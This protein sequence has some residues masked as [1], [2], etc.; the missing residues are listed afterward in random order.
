MFL[1]YNHGTEL[2]CI[3]GQ[4]RLNTIKEYI[5]QDSESDPW[6]W[7][8][9]DDERTEYIYY[10]N[11]DTEA[12]IITFCKQ[13]NSKKR[14]NKFHRLMTPV[15][16]KR[17]REY[18]CMITEI[19][20]PLT[21]EERQDL[22]TRWQSGT[23]ISQCDKLK[24]KPFAF[25]TFVMENGL[26]KS[27]VPQIN[28]IVRSDKNWLFDLFRLLNAFGVA[29]LEKA[30]L[31]SLDIR[32]LMENDNMPAHI[33]ISL[34]KCTDFLDKCKCLYNKKLYNSILSSIAFEWNRAPKHVQAKIETESFVEKL[35]KKLEKIEQN[36]LNNTPQKEI[37]LD[38]YSDFKVIFE[39]CLR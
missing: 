11:P 20:S 31:S 8:K 26:E 3:D 6:A 28:Q 33:E 38:N 34:P 4:N 15:E 2:Q 14:N 36:T 13:M 35:L 9:E 21:L 29:S 5:N 7:I 17:F 23:P 39:A 30:M 1:L 24:N 10:N 16:A 22:F 12:S 27:I 25:C 18:L 32:R 19:R 37:V